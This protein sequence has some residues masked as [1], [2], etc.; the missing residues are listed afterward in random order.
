[1]RMKNPNLPKMMSKKQ[2]NTMTMIQ[3]M[4]SEIKMNQTMMK[5]L[6]K[7]K[8]SKKKRKENEQNENI[9]KIKQKMKK[10]RRKRKRKKIKHKENRFVGLAK[11]GR[12]G[13]HRER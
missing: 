7:T 13:W 6:Q 4:I 9:K 10:K 3:K 5:K 2:K 1:M 8:K 12:N 11:R